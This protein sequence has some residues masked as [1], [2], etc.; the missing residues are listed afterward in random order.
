MTFMPLNGSQKNY[1]NYLCIHIKFTFFSN[2]YFKMKKKPDQF[3][4]KKILLIYIPM[5]W[6]ELNFQRTYSF[7]FC[8]VYNNFTS[9][10]K[11]DQI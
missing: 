8:T 2:V 5:L 6:N 4:A 7:T 3:I 10:Q 1:P 9:R 11:I